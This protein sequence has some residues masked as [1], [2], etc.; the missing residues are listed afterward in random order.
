MTNKMANAA[1]AAAPPTT[2]ATVDGERHQGVDDSPAVAVTALEPD[3][4]QAS[5]SATV[6]HH[7][8]VQRHF[9][10]QASSRHAACR[11]ESALEL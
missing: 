4:T 7:C 5:K 1:A 6:A 8:S 2:N 3:A 10:W 9:A 11:Y